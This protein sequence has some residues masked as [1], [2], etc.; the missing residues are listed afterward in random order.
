MRPIVFTCA[1]LAAVAISPS[2]WSVQ[3]QDWLRQAIPLESRTHDFGT[4]ARAANTEHR[5]YITNNQASDL[6]LRSARASCG[7]TTPIIETE[8]IKP[9]QTGSVLARFN[10]GTFTGK[11]AATLTISIDKPNYTELQLNVTGYIRSD[12]VLNPGEVNFGEVPVGEP[13]TMDVSLDY[14]GRSDWKLLSVDSP[15]EFMKIDFAEVSRNG[16]RIS[17]KITA[18]LD[19]QAPLGTF[20]NQFLLRTNDRNLTTLPIAVQADVQSPIQVSPQSLALGSVKSG[21][22]IIQRLVIKGRTEFRILQISCDHAEVRYEASED[23]KTVHLLSLTIQPKSQ[24]ADG[25][26]SSELLLLTDASEQPIRVPF[27]FTLATQS[28]VDSVV[29]SD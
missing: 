19:Q 3:A 15:A 12:V 27:T 25:L 10:T 9:G 18:S 24:P 20:K 26:I 11:K 6:H 13:K 5:F 17:Y 16:G 7:C 21:E 14:A 29:V 8:W 22:P 2:N 1:T 23:S 4:V 28:S